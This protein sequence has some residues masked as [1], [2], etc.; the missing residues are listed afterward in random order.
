MFH[1]TPEQAATLTAIADEGSFE[2]AALRLHVTPSAVSQRVRALEVALGR[3]ALRRVRPVELTEAGRV[4]VRHAR[5]LD[6]L[7]AEL[8]A[9]LALEEGTGAVTVVVNGDSLSTWA[10]PALTRAAEHVRLQ[11]LRE[12]QDHSLQLLRDGVASGAVTAAAE[13]VPGCSSRRLGVLRYRAVCA[14]A[15]AARW[16]PD[17]V[18]ARSLGKAPV[19]IYD[20]KDD[21]QDRLLRRYA[22]ERPDPPRHW[23]PATHEFG[24]AVRLGLG[25]GMLP[26]LQIGNGLVRGRFVALAP[27][28]PVDVVLHWQQWRSAP[29]GL[30]RVAEALLSAGA[31]ALR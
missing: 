9:E 27:A 23:I 19:V 7:A 5:R 12:D 16:F 13:P 11:V 30:V 4:L 17:G 14:P 29:P 10:L 20:D 8:A 2:G 22:A 21:L 28:E 3:P 24:E 31:A 25:W 26:E 15:F 18:D 1:L 6:L